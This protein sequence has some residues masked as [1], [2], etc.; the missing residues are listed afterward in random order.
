M[1]LDDNQVRAEA[2]AADLAR[3][4]ADEGALAVEAPPVLD[5]VERSVRVERRFLEAMQKTSRTRATAVLTGWAAADEAPAILR[6]L[7]SVSDGRCVVQVEGTDSVAEDDIPVRLRHRRLLR[8]FEMLVSAYG[9]PRY[10]DVEP[11]LFVALTYL[12]MFGMMFGDAGHGAVLAA[13]GLVALF[14]GRTRKVRDTGLLI[15]FGGLSSVAFGVA[16]GSYFGIP[17]LRPYGVWVDPLAGNPVRFLGCAI[18]IG[19]VMLSLGL[20][21]NIVNRLRHGDVV[22]GVVDKYGVF[23]AVFYWAALALVAKG[24]ALHSHQPMAPLLVFC[25]ALPLAGWVMR[26]PLHRARGRLSG[27]TQGSDGTLAAVLESVV[28]AFEEILGYLANTISFVRI[29]AYAMSHGALLVATYALAEE[30]RRIQPGGAAMGVLAILAGNAVAIVL[31]GLVA[32]VQALRLEYYEFFSK[33]QSGTGRRFEPFCLA[34]GNREAC[35][36]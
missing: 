8:P 4:R 9:L 31:E 20:T 1:L 27:A 6:R 3:V 24:A 33:F 26:G 13:A 36:T 22:G 18:A 21:L 7:R 28:E 29:A 5:R 14:V 34:S 17:A 16:Y 12:L 15:L 30:V 23:G 32:A 35:E 19:V 2:T 11:T 10:R 25:L